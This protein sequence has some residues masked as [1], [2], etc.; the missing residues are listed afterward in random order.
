M[1]KKIGEMYAT[2]FL[3]FEFEQDDKHLKKEAVLV[4][5]SWWNNYHGDWESSQEQILIP[6]DKI[7]DFIQMLRKAKDNR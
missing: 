3:K 4:R 2:D 5:A 1:V 7:D 6:L